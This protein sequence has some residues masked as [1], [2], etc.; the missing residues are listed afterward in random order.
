[1]GERGAKVDEV[2]RKMCRAVCRAVASGA[3]LAGS[4]A[5]MYPKAPA[6]TPPVAAAGTGLNWATVT[7]AVKTE[8]ITATSAT[9]AADLT[10]LAFFCGLRPGEI[11]GPPLGR[12]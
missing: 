12:L 5:R 10:A 4:C 3:R 6:A 1:M 2:C 7:T 9:P 11:W 8:N